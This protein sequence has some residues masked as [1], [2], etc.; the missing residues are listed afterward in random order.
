[1]ARLA[2][3]AA[4]LAPAAASAQ[5]TITSSFASTFT[6]G[7]AQSVHIGK[8]LCIPDQVIDFQYNLGVVPTPGVDTVQAWI[9]KDSGACSTTPGD[10]PAPSQPLSVPSQTSQTG[11][12]LLHLRVGELLFPDATF[13]G[14][15][16]NT[17]SRAAEPFNELFCVRRV[18]AAVFGGNPTVNSNTL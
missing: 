5:F 4:L 2:L 11:V 3:V 1:M 18:S 9:V 14:G 8:S 17:T 13:P 15:C 16:A 6:T 7:E 10:P 12:V